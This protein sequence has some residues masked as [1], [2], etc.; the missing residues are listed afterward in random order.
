MDKS[1]TLPGPNKGKPG[2]ADDTDPL[3]TRVNINTASFEEL[4]E[5][6]HI[7][8]AW[9]QEVIEL[10]PF[11]SLDQLTQVSG[12]GPARLQDIKDEKD[13]IC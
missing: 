12:I 2:Y 6:F 1:V 5:I 3:P 10:R 7:G 9:A 11:T 8:E 4:Q 13:C